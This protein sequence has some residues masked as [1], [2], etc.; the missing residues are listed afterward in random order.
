MSCDVCGAQSGRFPLCRSCNIKKEKGEVVKCS[1]CQSWHLSSGECKSTQ[2]REEIINNTEKVEVSEKNENKKETFIYNLKSSLVTQLEL[3]YLNCIKSV[4]PEGY[5]VQ[6][7]ANLATFIDKT[8]GSAFQNE[9]FR[10]VDFIIV[11]FNYKPIL[12]IEVN[13]QSHLSKDR[14]VRDK[15]VRLI[16]EEAGIPLITLWTSYGV[17]SE[18]IAKRIEE[19]IASLPIKR[20][21]HSAN[22]PATKSSKK[23]QSS[24][25]CYIATSVYGSYDC[26]QVWVLRRFRDEILASKWYGLLFIKIY[27]AI[28][29]TLVKLFGNYSLFKRFW[30]R[31]L[32]NMVDKLHSFGLKNTPYE[33][34]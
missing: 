6:A 13:D 23:S 26:P 33:D 18:Y 12:L 21:A 31:I 17:N 5:L 8:D 34:R 14:Q 29:P 32:D 4:L 25:G 10:N 1:K 24:G 3:K 30:G 27:Y 2:K 28:S 19:G 11:D 7:Q 22:K 20:I 9:L 16:C 15:K